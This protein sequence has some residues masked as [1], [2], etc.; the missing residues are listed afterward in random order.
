MA[1]RRRPAIVSR[2][3]AASRVER[4]LLGELAVPAGKLYGIRTVR[5]LRNLSFSGRVLGAY[6]RYVRALA[7]VKKAAARANR[8]ARVIDSRIA[9]AIEAACDEILI[10]GHRLEFPVDVLGGGGSIAINMNV[11]EAIANLAN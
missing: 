4:D 6:P 8:E 3:V 11:N 9:S 10:S 7:M 5:A 1:A 2:E